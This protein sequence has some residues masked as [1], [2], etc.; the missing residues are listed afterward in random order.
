[1]QTT[2]KDALAK[3][4]KQ[5]FTGAACKHGHVSARRTATG[6]CL[7]CRTQ[8][9][10]VWREKNP[11]KVKMHNASQYEKH[12]EK[13]K[14][15]VRKWEKQNPVKVRAHTRLMQSKRKKRCP[16]WLTPDDLWMMQQA[17]ELAALRTKLFGFQW[18]VDH[19]IPLQGK[20]VSGLHVPQNLRVI[21]GF[22]NVRKANRYEVAA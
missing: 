18:H 3:G 21:P 15:G 13:I 5:Y 16:A 17:Y 22:E 10:F 2:R 9:L 14:E 4:E 12:S 6:E 20:L 1:M 7:E 8:A 19:E 11:D